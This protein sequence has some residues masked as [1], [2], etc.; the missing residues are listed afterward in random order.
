MKQVPNSTIPNIRKNYTV[1]D[2]ADGDRK[3]MYIN[4]KGLIYL[5]DTNMNV[6]FTGAKT[7]NEDLLESLLDGEHIKNSKTGVGKWEYFFFYLQFYS[8]VV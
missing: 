6:V 7:E 3:L 1:T 5:I 8:V 4:A 2:K